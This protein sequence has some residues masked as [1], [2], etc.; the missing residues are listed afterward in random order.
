MTIAKVIE[1][2]SESDKSWD[3]A[4]QKAVDEASKTVQGI[5]SIWVDNFTAVVENGKVSKYRLNGKVTFLIER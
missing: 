3:D 4:A 2:I 5:K 1:V